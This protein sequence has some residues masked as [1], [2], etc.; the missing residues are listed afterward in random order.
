L[1]AFEIWLNDNVHLPLSTLLLAPL[2]LGALLRRYGV[3]LFRTNA[4]LYLFIDSINSVV[5]ANR[6][7][8]YSLRVAWD[9]VT[10]WRTIEPVHP[11]PPLPRAI[12]RAMVVLSILWGWYGFSAVT[13]I[14]FKGISRVGEPLFSIR[15]QYQTPSDLLAD[16]DE[17]SPENSLLLSIDRPGTGRRGGA[18]QQ[19]ISV[20]AGPEGSG[21]CFHR[22]FF[23]QD[24][25][26]WGPARIA[27]GG[28]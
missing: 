18:P 10:I 28:T 8:Q 26:R 24:C 22:W 11:R 17:F 6:D 4:P 19:H 21:C 3:H 1:E 14:A 2:C 27:S 20:N 25:S 7:L 15:N 12:F 23:L 13:I 5:D 9:T 16:V